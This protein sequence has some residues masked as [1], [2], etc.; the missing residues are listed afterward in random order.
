[1]VRWQHSPHTL[2]QN[3][4]VAKVIHFFRTNLLQ[5]SNSN[6]I[7]IRVATVTGLNNGM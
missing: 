6:T 3:N 2:P 1:M 4:C 7:L 5:Y